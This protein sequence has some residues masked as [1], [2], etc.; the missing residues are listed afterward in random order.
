MEHD[1]ELMLTKKAWSDPDFAALLERDPHA[2]LTQLGVTVAKDTKLK[3]IVQKPNTLYFTIPPVRTDLENR[4]PISPAEFQLNQI[5]IWS[6]SKMF[7]WIA[8]ARQKVKL[9]QMRNS[10]Y[11]R[12]AS[13]E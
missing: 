11:E 1:F 13:D 12:K 9:L 7:I 3:I 8:A 6:S 2:A 5:D 10:I 4:P